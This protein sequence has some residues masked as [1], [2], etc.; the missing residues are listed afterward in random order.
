MSTFTEALSPVQIEGRIREVANQIAQGVEES[1]R[2]YTEFQD[3]ESEYNLEYA[4]AFL[5]ATGAQ[6]EK[7]YK[8][9]VATYELR[10]KMN[11]A[12]IAYRHADRKAKALESEL[13]AYQSVGASIRAA[14]KVAGRGEY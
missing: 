4:K 3:A 7:R 12:K 13:R 2:T 9:D 6:Y 5:A 8:A 1:T 14:Y 11:V 10:E